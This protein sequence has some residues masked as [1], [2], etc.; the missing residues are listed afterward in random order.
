[1]LS[2]KAISGFVSYYIARVHLYKKSNFFY[3]EKNTY[4]KNNIKNRS[5]LVPVG[6][7]EE[8]SKKCLLITSD[9]FPTEKNKS[10][11]IS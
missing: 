8:K 11:P 5:I 7:M 1:M 2:W 6:K 4:I 10:L 3:F 9:D